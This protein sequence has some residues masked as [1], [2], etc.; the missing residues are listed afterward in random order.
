MK[1]ENNSICS[2]PSS[3]LL[4][5]P[6][7]LREAERLAQYFNIPLYRES[8]LTAPKELILRLIAPLL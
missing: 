8:G 1:K 5:D 6:S 4:T 7:R 2:G 3:L